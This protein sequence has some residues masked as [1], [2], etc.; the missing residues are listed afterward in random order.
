[1]RKWIFDGYDMVN[2]GVCIM[3][4]ML[5][6]ASMTLMACSDH[7]PK[8]IPE[9]ATRRIV[10]YCSHNR[11]TCLCGGRQYKLSEPAE[12]PAEFPISPIQ[13][14]GSVTTKVQDE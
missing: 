14:N 13:S 4:L 9:L 11:V 7:K 12:L 10:C 8:V 6:T 1:M 5:A 2:I 3:L